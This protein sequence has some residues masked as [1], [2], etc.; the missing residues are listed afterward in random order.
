ML[1]IVL[2]LTLGAMLGACQYESGP[3]NQ[4]VAPGAQRP[5]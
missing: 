3:P 5:V 4:T 1:R 2:L